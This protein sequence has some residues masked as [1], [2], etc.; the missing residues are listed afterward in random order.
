VKQLL[1]TL[2]YLIALPF[3]QNTLAGQPLIVPLEDLS[4][5]EYPPYDQQIWL[6]LHNG[7]VE[8]ADR[9]LIAKMPETAG[10]VLALTKRN[11]LADAQRIALRI[12]ETHP[13]E[14]PHVF[15][16]LMSGASGLRASDRPRLKEVMG[17]VADADAARFVLRNVY[18]ARTQQR[19]TSLPEPPRSLSRRSV[20]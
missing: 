3:S 18:R 11:R 7:M 6:R 4:Y 16:A 9:L 2:L 13:E 1:V 10:A 17:T 14:I 15:D 12:V 8:K 20:A 5:A 19:A